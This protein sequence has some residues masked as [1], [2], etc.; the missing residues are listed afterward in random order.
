[1]KVEIGFVFRY[2]FTRTVTSVH[3]NLTY[4]SV[5]RMMLMNISA[6]VK[7]LLHVMPDQVT[8]AADI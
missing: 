1:M 4:S 6:D 3:Q 8:R 2:S 5:V 7:Y